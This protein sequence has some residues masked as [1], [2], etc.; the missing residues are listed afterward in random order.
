MCNMYNIW[1]RTIRKVHKDEM[2][3][4]LFSAKQFHLVLQ[5][6]GERTEMDL[7]LPGS[8]GIRW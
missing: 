7:K 4:M 1:I 2:E 8:L 3:D 5:C 6:F